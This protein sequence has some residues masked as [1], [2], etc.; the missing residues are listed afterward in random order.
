MIAAVYTVFDGTAIL[1]GSPS[2]VTDALWRGCRSH[3][4]LRTR[5]EFMAFQAGIEKNWS[6]Y[7]LDTSNPE[8]F[9]RGLVECGY[10]TRLA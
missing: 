8:A 10:L 4:P 1:R 9:V 2:E 3:V 7:A 6:G 5:S